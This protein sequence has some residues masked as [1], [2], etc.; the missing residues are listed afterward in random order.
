MADYSMNYGGNRPAVQ[1]Y[2]DTTAGGPVQP[3]YTPIDFGGNVSGQPGLTQGDALLNANNGIPVDNTNM[4]W[5][6]G[7][8]G[9]TGN[10]VPGLQA[11]SGAANA[12]LGY[13]SLKLGEKQF[14]FM[15]GRY[16]QDGANQ[17][18]VYNNN[19]RQQVENELR[20]RGEL[21]S[22]SQEFTAAVN[23]KADANKIDFKS[24]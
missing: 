4:D 22:G 24:L 14:D 5:L 20:S 15:Q 8:D 19:Y 21:D 11:L 6:F 13:K 23:A 16:N 7:K 12:Y 17:T 9:K 18:A 10:L 3:G 2:Y 1:N